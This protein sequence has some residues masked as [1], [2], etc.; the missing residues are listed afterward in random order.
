MIQ[1]V[2]NFVFILRDSNEEESNGLLIP[3]QSQEKPNHGTIHSVGQNV[4]DK[5]I[6]PGKKCLFFKG[7][8]FDIPFE[9]TDYLVIEGERIIGIT[10]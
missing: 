1:A 4:Q 6:K 10:T 8:G 2:N 5:K 3:G 7:N 9:G